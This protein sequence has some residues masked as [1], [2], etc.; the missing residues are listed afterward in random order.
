MEGRLMNDELDTYVD[1]KVDVDVRQLERLVAER[2]AKHPTLLSQPAVR[3]PAISMRHPHMFTALTA[4]WFTVC[5]DVAMNHFTPGLTLVLYPVAQPGTWALKWWIAQPL[6]GAFWYGLLMPLTRD[7]GHQYYSTNPTTIVVAVVG[8]FAVTHLA[9]V[10]YPA[11]PMLYAAGFGHGHNFAAWLLSLG[12][13]L[14]LNE[15][16]SKQETS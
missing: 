6:I 11:D 14:I 8:V 13:L 1:V 12:E 2:A 10:R 15:I 4:F 3:M 16:A 5:V 9:L 7:M